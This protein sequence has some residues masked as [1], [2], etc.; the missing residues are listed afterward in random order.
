MNAAYR[1]TWLDRLRIAVRR[2]L[3]KPVDFG[4]LVRRYREINN[5]S[6]DDLALRCNIR[7]ARLR[8]IEGGVF[9]PTSKEIFRLQKELDIPDVVLLEYV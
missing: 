5:W 1:I 4:P 6:L 9:L 3:K 2:Y 7:W 8:F